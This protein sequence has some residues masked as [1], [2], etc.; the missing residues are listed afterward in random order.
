[1]A[2]PC[3]PQRGR[4]PPPLPRRGWRPRR[5]RFG[6]RHGASSW[7][8]RRRSVRH[9][10][11]TRQRTCWVIM[12][13]LLDVFFVAFLRRLSSSPFFVAFLR[14]LSPTVRRA[15]RQLAFS[16]S[17]RRA[18]GRALTPLKDAHV[19]DVDV[20]LQPLCPHEP[21]ADMSRGA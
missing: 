21:K 10:P 15:E 19:V 14:L 16:G 8:T 6:E 1:A 9:G 11:R 18:P 3:L 20:A 7:P 4:S 2:R 12:R 5:G 13:L 17:S